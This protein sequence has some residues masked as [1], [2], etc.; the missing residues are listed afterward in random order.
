MYVMSN[1]KAITTRESE[2]KITQATN[3]GR[4]MVRAGV[5][6]ELFFRKP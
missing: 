3:A 1:V 2:E 5:V 4:L 6:C